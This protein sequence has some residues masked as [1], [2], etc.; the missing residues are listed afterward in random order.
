MPKSFRIDPHLEQR[1]QAVAKR[2]AVPV[3]EVVRVAIARHCDDVLGNDAASALADVIGIMKSEGGRA[4]RTGRAFKDV[5]AKR[6][7]R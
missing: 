3:S 2:Q 5:L 1:L 6:D 7:R 4:E